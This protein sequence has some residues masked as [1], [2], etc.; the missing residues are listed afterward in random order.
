MRCSPPSLLLRPPSLRL[1]ARPPLVVLYELEE[2]VRPLLERGRHH[3]KLEARA[4]I[5]DGV[6][7]TAAGPPLAA[8]GHATQALTPNTFIRA[9][10]SS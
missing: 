10:L 6:L 9:R 4:R 3:L 8:C 5:A 7:D 2:R 1:L